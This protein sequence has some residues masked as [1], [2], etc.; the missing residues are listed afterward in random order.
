MAVVPTPQMRPLKHKVERLESFSKP[1]S[2]PGTL[3]HAFPQVSRLRGRLGRLGRSATQG[4][5]A[6]WDVAGAWAGES[7]CPQELGRAGRS[8]RT[9]QLISPMPEGHISGLPV[10]YQYLL[11]TIY[12]KHHRSFA[13]CSPFYSLFKRAPPPGLFRPQGCRRLPAAPE[14]CTGGT[15]GPALLAFPLP[16][17]PADSLGRQRC[18]GLGVASRR[19]WAASCTCCQAPPNRAG[20]ACNL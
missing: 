5:S 19:R 6:P 18:E 10:G 8:S 7:C 3:P 9:P 20:W 1:R 13:S 14:W 4:S 16:G 12:A 2:E 17:A 15:G 11:P